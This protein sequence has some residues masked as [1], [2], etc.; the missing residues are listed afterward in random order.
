MDKSYTSILLSNLRKFLFEEGLYTEE[1]Y[2]ACIIVLTRMSINIQTF[3]NLHEILNYFIFN[4]VVFTRKY[5][6]DLKSNIT[7][8]NKFDNFF[9][10]SESDFPRLSNKED[11]LDY[12]KTVRYLFD[13]YLQSEH[14]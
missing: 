8:K 7:D 6:L 9:K 14:E 11:K 1:N 10:F 13:Q 2:S 3:L 5:N 12:W 4:T